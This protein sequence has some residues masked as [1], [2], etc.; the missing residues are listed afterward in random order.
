MVPETPEGDALFE[1][2]FQA[3]AV[4]MT[5]IDPAGRFVRCNAAFCTMVGYDEAEL[6]GRPV[7]DFVHRDDAGDHG[8]LLT[9]L[10]SGARTS[11]QVSKR[12]WH[13]DGRV[14]HVHITASRMPG[15]LV[16]G[17]IRDITAET[18]AREQLRRS[19]E[20]LGIALASV[21]MGFFEWDVGADRMIWSEEMAR[22]CG[23]DATPAGHRFGTH[24]DLIHADDVQMVSDAVH[25]A[26][27]DKTRLGIECEFRI[28]R[29]DRDDRWFLGKAHIF[30]DED[31]KP[32]RLLGALIDVT[33]RHQLHE[34]F[35]QAQK[36]EAVGTF[37]SGI[38]HDFNNALMVIMGHCDVME[39]VDPTPETLQEGLV[40]ISNA[41]ER[42]A[43]LTR[44]LLMF[45]R[46][47]STD[48][49]V[50]NPN[51]TLRNL[52]G[53]LRPLTGFHQLR[54]QLAPA[55]AAVR[56]DERQLEQAIVNLVVNARDA[57]AVQGVITVTTAMTPD[58]RVAIS[59]SDT[60]TGIDEK[61][62]ARLFEPFFTTKAPGK[63]TG[64]GLAVVLAVAEEAKGEVRVE[65]AAGQ[66]ATFELRFPAAV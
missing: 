28:Q 1:S 23:L 66:G 20:Q 15:G 54:L 29:P 51:E 52:E 11:Y 27:H 57:M 4:G 10:L 48:L 12:Y 5:L 24:F 47:G 18:E 30:R 55:V 41:A 26:V 50:I 22:L 7:L 6:R 56:I 63:G 59:V 35:L 36:M 42:A 39:M 61:T 31:G 64:L 8:V 25:S 3:A 32:L 60:G 46:K 40:E 2:V 9:Q 13:H 37:A 34:Q 38:A 53:F 17:I 33:R 58:G 45:S 62:K 21:E 65:S 16:I 19:Q 43:H 44:Q 49:R 14:I